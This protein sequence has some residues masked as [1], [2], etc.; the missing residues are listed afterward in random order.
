MEIRQKRTHE[1]YTLWLVCDECHRELRRLDAQEP[2]WCAV[3]A[4]DEH[5]TMTHRVER[6]DDAVGKMRYRQPERKIQ[7]LQLPDA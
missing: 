6:A 7:T 5:K 3:V 1:G 4:L 2:L